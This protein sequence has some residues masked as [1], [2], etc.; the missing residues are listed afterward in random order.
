MSKHT[1]IYV[2]GLGDTRTGGRRLL[3]ASWRL[4][5][6]R[7]VVHQ[8]NWAD[9][10]PFEIKFRALL[11]HIDE[12]IAAGERVSLVGESAGASVT[13]EAYAA[14][15]D[16][17]HRVACICGKLRHPET[18][19]PDTYRKNPAFAEAMAALPSALTGL[20]A[21]KLTRVRSLHPLVD[22]TVPV[23]DTI[24]PGVEERAIPTAGHATSIVLGN[25]LFSWR[26][27]PF[28]KRP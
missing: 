22:P 4:Y 9:K 27:V 8:M 1:V 10:Q 25:L 2:P 3:I 11:K 17:I 20:N 28:L 26:L 15:Q 6:V 19:H 18:I 21:T 23:A 13:L 12:R 16:T 7:P 24:I 5:G 14:R